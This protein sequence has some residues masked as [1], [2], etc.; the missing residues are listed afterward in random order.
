M[1]RGA[2]AE[3]WLAVSTAPD[4]ETAARLGRRAVE[5]RHAACANVLPGVRSIYRWKGAVEETPEILVLFKTTAAAYPGLARL[6]ATEHPYEVPELLAFPAVDGLP[7]YLDW[8][9]AE[10]APVDTLGART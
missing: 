2:G 9:R 4:A 5:G 7:L 8:V 1:S 10:A 3:V 6:I